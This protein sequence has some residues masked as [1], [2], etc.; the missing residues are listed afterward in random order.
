MKLIAHLIALL[1]LAV[2]GVSRAAAA[3][4][5][6]GVRAFVV[7]SLCVSASV[8]ANDYQ[9]PPSQRE[10]REYM[11][12]LHNHARG[13]NAKRIA[14]EIRE[15]A[16]A[17]DLDGAQA[18]RAE[19]EAQMEWERLLLDRRNAYAKNPDDL[20]S[21]VRISEALHGGMDVNRQVGKIHYLD[22]YK[23]SDA[24]GIAARSGDYRMAAILLD[25]GADVNSETAHSGIVWRDG[26][27]EEGDE[28][29]FGFHASYPYL[30]HYVDGVD[31]DFYEHPNSVKADELTMRTLLMHG[32][33]V[34]VRDLDGWTPLHRTVVYALA[35]NYAAAQNFAAAENTAILAKLLINHGADVNAKINTKGH[36]AGYTPLHLAAQYNTA[37][38][39]K[40]LI[41]GGADVHAKTEGER[42][43][44]GYTPLHWAARRKKST[45]IARMLIVKGADV[46]AKAKHGWTPLHNAALVNATET[47]KLLIE[48]G[49]DV[50]AIISVV[51]SGGC[52]YDGQT[53]LDMAIGH[54][55]LNGEEIRELLINAGARCN[56]ETGPWCGNTVAPEPKADHTGL[57]ANA[58]FAVAGA[59]APSW[60]DTQTFAFNEGDKLVTGQSLSVPLDDFTFAAKRVQVNDLTD[61]EFAV[62]WEMEF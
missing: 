55:Y 43:Y 38:V 26:D 12:W 5:R 27:E 29:I 28:P 48:N 42:Y 8:Y 25:S 2:E 41:D 50:N 13:L 39:A 17:G 6:S 18:Q 30:W 20:M 22:S 52:C 49:A 16:T 46:N 60:V 56:I 54:I 24:L 9:W 37:E 35:K 32:A 47:A 23:T 1:S 34:N 15:K 7:L 40:L 4:V 31:H 33:D 10:Y 53:P 59:F 61:Y 36:L 45:E 57:Y 19:F 14:N 58:A 44:T 3:C 62:K 11:E 51:E 21:I